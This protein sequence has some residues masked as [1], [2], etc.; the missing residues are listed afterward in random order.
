MRILRDLEK[1]TMTHTKERLKPQERK[2]TLRTLSVLKIE[3]CH[4]N[5]GIIKYVKAELSL[6]CKQVQMGD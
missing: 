1:N 3:G 5:L 6:N 4:L 2:E